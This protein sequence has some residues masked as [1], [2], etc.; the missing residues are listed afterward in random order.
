LVT[1]LDLPLCG[2]CEYL[3]LIDWWIDDWMDGWMD[4]WMQG[5]IEEA[6]FLLVVDEG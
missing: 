3:Y 6:D 2:H 1:L 4:G 5:L